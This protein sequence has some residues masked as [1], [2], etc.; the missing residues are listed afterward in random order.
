V[1]GFLVVFFCGSLLAK[2]YWLLVLFAYFLVGVWPVAA[3]A[4]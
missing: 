4:V 3:A 1:A 2:W